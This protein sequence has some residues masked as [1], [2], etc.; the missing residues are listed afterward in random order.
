MYS[1]LSQD[2]LARIH[3]RQGRLAEA[4][5]AARRACAE[6]V[7]LP[8]FEPNRHAMLIHIL[9][10]GGRPTEAAEVAEGVLALLQRFGCLGN[11]EVELR[12]AVS[13]VFYAVGQLARAHAEL[14]ETL[15][16]IEIRADDI[17][18]PFWRTSYLTRNPYCARA[19]ALAK[20]WELDVV[21][22]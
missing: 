18:D 2:V 17:P 15:R 11:A 6:G 7:A 21:V 22:K 13:E 10:A 1:M 5:A 19:Q 14:H 9:L 12:L 3:L 20:D 16:Q 8:A 4:E